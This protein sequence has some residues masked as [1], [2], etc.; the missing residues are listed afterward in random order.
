MYGE[1]S[2]FCENY[3]PNIDACDGAQSL[4]E[5]GRLYNWYAVDD[6]RGLCPSGWHVPTDCE[7]TDLENYIT[8]QGFS[9]IEGTSLKS[10]YGWYDGGNGTDNFGFSALPG[11]YR[12]SSAMATSAMPGTTATGGVLRPVAALLG[13][14][15]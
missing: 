8:S 2:S 13:T 5:Y 1:G 3:S 9:G 7:W 6:A 15:T 14:G 10:T 4:A 12:N 11:G